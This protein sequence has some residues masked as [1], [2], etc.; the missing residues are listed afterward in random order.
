[1]VDD[2]VRL[3]SCRAS[4]LDVLLEFGTFLSELFSARLP[5]GYRQQCDP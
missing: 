1:M 2:V 4:V 5:R 3:P